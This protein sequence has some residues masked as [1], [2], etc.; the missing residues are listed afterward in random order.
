[1]LSRAPKIVDN[2]LRSLSEITELVSQTVNQGA[3]YGRAECIECIRSSLR[4][5]ISLDRG[6]R[7]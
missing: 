3:L 5:E 1:V 2:S 6:G 7:R 4:S